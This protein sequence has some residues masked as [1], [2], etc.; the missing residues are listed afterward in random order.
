MNCQLPDKFYNL[1]A[2][3]GYHFSKF[4]FKLFQIGADQVNREFSLGLFWRFVSMKCTYVAIVRYEQSKQGLSI[5][6]GDLE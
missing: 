4:L 3:N 5:Q 6:R 2:Q 1:L